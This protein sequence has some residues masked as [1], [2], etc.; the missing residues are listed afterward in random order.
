M[1]LSCTVLEHSCFPSLSVVRNTRI[2]SETE[3]SSLL[4]P[5]SES[6][7]YLIVSECASHRIQTDTLDNEHEI[8]I[9]VTN[10]KMPISFFIFN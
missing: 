2:S 7:V 6:L 3:S 8:L 10:T 4:C 9:I 1:V 5:Y